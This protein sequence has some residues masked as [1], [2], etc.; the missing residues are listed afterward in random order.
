KRSWN[1]WGL[2]VFQ[3][4][5]E[6]KLRPIL[7]MAGDPEEFRTEGGIPCGAVTG[8][9]A[10]MQKWIVRL[11]YCVPAA[12]ARLKDPQAKYYAVLRASMPRDVAMA[13]AANPSTMI[14]LARAGDAHKESLIRDIRDGTLT[15]G[16]DW[17]AEVRQAM[18]RKL[19]RDKAAAARLEKLAS[20][21][22]QLFPKDYWGEKKWLMGN[23]MGGSMG[24]YLRHYP[25]YFGDAKVRDVGLIAS[26]GRMTIPFSDGTPSGVL[27]ITSHYFEFIPEA[28]AESASPTVLGAHELQEGGRYFI[29]LTTAYGLY[30]YHIHD[31]V[32]CTGFHHKTPLVEF[33]SK[34]SLF[35]NLTGEKLSEYHVTQAVADVLAGLETTLGTYSVAP[36]WPE[37]EGRPPWYGLFVEGEPPAALAARLD[38][39]LRQ[40]N[41]EYDAKRESQR[42]GPVRLEPVPAGFWAKWDAERLKRNGG[43]LEQYKHPCLIGDLEFHK[44]A[45]G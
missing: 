1:V 29:L 34:G 41:I 35:S 38:E 3:D 6:L 21:T 9:T 13:I 37:E 26:E 33:L 44:R 43:T 7:S 45:R 10:R 17:P 19:N 23:W 25:K 27:D 42:L 5:P 20:R 28:E 8:L 12:L 31:L 14:S 24:A 36:C 30:R 22:G 16:F 39:R 15:G 11:F 40:V 4:Y 18:K 2:K 32:R